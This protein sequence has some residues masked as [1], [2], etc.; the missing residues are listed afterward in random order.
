MRE[1]FK[2]LKAKEEADEMRNRK[3]QNDALIQKELLKKAQELHQTSQRAIN[4]LHK[5][6]MAGVVVARKCKNVQASSGAQIKT[7][8]QRGGMG[9]NYKKTRSHSCMNQTDNIF[10]A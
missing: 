9:K 3:L 10:E 7:A 2:Q 6:K 5:S 1:N 4:N 8:N